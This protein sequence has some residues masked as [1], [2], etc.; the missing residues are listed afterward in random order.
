MDELNEAMLEHIQ[1]DCN[2]IYSITRDSQ[3]LYGFALPEGLHE[4]ASTCKSIADALWIKSYLS[5]RESVMD[6]QYILDR[7]FTP[8]EDYVYLQENQAEEISVRLS[9]VVFH[10]KQLGGLW[11]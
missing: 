7:R 11:N 3:L 5:F 10:L 1:A 2:A 4:L 6:L 9:N 8:D